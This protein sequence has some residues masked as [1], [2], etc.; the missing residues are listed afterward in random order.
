[1]GRN[2]AEVPNLL[3]FNF[4]KKYKPKDKLYHI[5]ALKCPKTDWIIVRQLL[6]CVRSLFLFKDAFHF[7]ACCYNM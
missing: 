7:L 1:M 5:C 4:L 6:T 2:L 3:T